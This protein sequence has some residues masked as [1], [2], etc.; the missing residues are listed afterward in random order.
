MRMTTKKNQAPAPFAGWQSVWCLRARLLVAAVGLL[1][2][3]CAWDPEWMQYQVLST[4]RQLAV[5]TL[6]YL[7]LPG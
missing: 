2:T 3:G 1:A 6:G 4:L 7:I 5:S